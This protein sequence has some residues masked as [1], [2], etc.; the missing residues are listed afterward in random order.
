[1]LVADR[2]VQVQCLLA[3]GERLV[4]VTSWAWY[5]PTAFRARAC[6]GR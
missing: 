2:L 4:V 5:H 3:A 6:P 1:V